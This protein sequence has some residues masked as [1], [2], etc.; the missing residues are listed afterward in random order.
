[1]KIEEKIKEKVI[2]D[3]MIKNITKVINDLMEKTIKVTMKSM[4]K[5]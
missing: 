4:K 1:M 2:T 5:K 3:K